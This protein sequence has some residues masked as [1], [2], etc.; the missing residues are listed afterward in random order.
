MDMQN[1]NIVKQNF[2]LEIEYHKFL[3]LEK[4]ISVV[5]SVIVSTK[6]QSIRLYTQTE[7][8]PKLNLV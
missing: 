6:T 8:V 7:D 5:C 4:S 3:V 2:L 1:S